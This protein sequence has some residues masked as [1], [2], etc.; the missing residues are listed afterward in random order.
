[1]KKFFTP[2]NVVHLILFSVA[3]NSYAL[4]RAFPGALILLVP[5]FIFINLLAGTGRMK[6]APIGL[7]ICRH[8]GVMLEIFAFSLIISIVYHVAL[9]FVT[10]PEDF[11]TLIWSAVI[12]VSLSAILFW[13]GIIC[14]YCTSVQLGIKIR[15]I[16]ALCGMIPV[17]NL[18]VLGKIISTVMNEVDFEWEKEK[19]NASRAAES[20]CKT[21]YPILLVHGIFFRDSNYFNYWGRIPKEL[22]R[23][24]ATVFYGEHQSALSIEDSAKELADRIKSIVAESGCEKLNVIAHSKG[25]LDCRCAISDLGIAPYVASLTTVS[26]PHRGCLFADRLLE[27]VPNALINKVAETYNST[28]KRLG[29]KN[30]DF[31]TSVSDLTK[32]ACERSSVN[33]TLPEGIYCQSFGSKLNRAQSGQFPLNLSYRLVKHYDGTNDGLVGVESFPWGERFELIT[34]KGERGIS[35]GDMIDLNRENIDG[36]DVREFYVDIVKDLKRRG[37]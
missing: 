3:A 5:S 10:L 2:I 26:T 30:P 17:A 20:V 35:H 14:V 33:W 9:A 7:R 15:V 36:F 21:K 37:L 11:M 8:G 19:V 27:M 25:G 12:C 32:S 16:G 31:I 28:L 29:D 4:I 23:N 18:I 22:K 34:V 1:M 6:G 13:N 24:G